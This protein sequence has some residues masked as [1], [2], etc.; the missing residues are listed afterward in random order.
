MGLLAMLLIDAVTAGGMRP[1]YLLLLLLAVI[2]LVTGCTIALLTLRNQRKNSQLAL[3]S[4]EQT[5]QEYP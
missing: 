3:I 1:L 2:L 5:E 4:L